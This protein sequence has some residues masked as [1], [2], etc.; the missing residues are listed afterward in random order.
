MTPQD[1]RRPEHG[2]DD[3]PETNAFPPVDG[4]AAP[5]PHE[6]RQPYQPQYVPG[7]EQPEARP[8]R[9]GLA[10]GLLALLI[11]GALALGVWFYSAFL[12]ADENG[13]PT[14][15]PATT[16]LTA[17]TSTPP[18][19]TEETTEETTTETTSSIEATTEITETTET[20]EE[21][22]DTPPPPTPT[23]TQPPSFRA[24]AGAE[25]CAANVNWRIFRV[26]DETSC[27]FAENVAIA[28][29][30]NSGQLN[31]HDVRA[32]SPVTGQTYTMRCGPEDGNSFTCRG[33]NNAVVVLE[34]RAV[35]D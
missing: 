17:P 31:I 25:Q 33:G 30:G 23:T 18:L 2:R 16:T 29:A 5:P 26:T 10:V 35:R 20:T 22:T 32:E 4:N 19:T 11:I 24:S 6:Q 3:E 12:T 7:R 9:S 27:E 1:P 8:R 15:A 21:E 28:M 34:D 13:E 14:A